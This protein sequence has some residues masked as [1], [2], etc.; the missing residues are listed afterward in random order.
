[1][2]RWMVSTPTAVKSRKIKLDPL[3]SSYVY[4]EMKCEKYIAENAKN[5]LVK[6]YVGIHSTRRIVRHTIVTDRPI[7]TLSLNVT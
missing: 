2:P 3:G 1:M 5:Q 4:R 6:M 7:C